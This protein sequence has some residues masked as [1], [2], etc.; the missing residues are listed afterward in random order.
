[1]PRYLL[2]AALLSALALAAPALAVEPARHSAD[3]GCPSPADPAESTA[4]SAGTALTPAKSPALAPPPGSQPPQRRSLS[5]GEGTRVPLRWH[6]FV[7]GMF[8]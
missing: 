3:G 6:S 2:I 8:M 4:A 5:T 1:M 7:P